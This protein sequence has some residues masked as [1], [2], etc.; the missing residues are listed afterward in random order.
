[1]N[2]DLLQVLAMSKLFTSNFH[3][4]NEAQK[5]LAESFYQLSLKE[6][7]LNVSTVYFKKLFEIIVTVF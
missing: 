5:G 2:F 4:M 6:M 3:Q 1:M 7:S